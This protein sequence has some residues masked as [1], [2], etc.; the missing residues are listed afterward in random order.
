MR[1]ATVVAS[2]GLIAKELLQVAEYT[3]GTVSNVSSIRFSEGDCL[4]TLF[5]RYRTT[6]NNLNVQHGVLFLIESRSS[7]HQL[8]ASHLALQY[9]GSKIVTGINLPMLVSLFTSENHETSPYILADRAQ[10]YGRLA[11]GLSQTPRRCAA[12]R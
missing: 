9:P 10:E 1:G 4:E 2:N 8:V 7:A 12:D 3:V 11:N 6:L 5:E